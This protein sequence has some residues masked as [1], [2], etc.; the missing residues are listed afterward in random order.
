MDRCAQTLGS[1]GRLVVRYSGTENKIRLLVEAKER[2]TVRHWIE[3][4]TAAVQA[5]MEG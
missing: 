2:E 1:D 3:E 5:D 4:L